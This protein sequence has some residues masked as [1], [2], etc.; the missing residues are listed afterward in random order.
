MYWGSYFGSFS[1]V[2]IHFFVINLFKTGLFSQYCNFLHF[3]GYT[4]R[5]V[6]TYQALI[7]FN[8]HC[9]SSLNLTTSRERAGQFEEFWESSVPRFGEEGAQGWAKWLDQKSKGMEQQMSFVDGEYKPV[10]FFRTISASFLCLENARQLRFYTVAHH[11]VS[12]GWPFDR[13]HKPGAAGGMQAPDSQ[14]LETA[15]PPL[16]SWLIRNF[17]CKITQFSPS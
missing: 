2:I 6:S 1:K 15:R 13:G 11:L 4:E 5:A 9:P 12:F 7:E 17:G 14:F 16:I 8:L 10:F 3:S